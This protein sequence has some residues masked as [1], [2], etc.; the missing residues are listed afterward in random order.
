MINA[1]TPEFVEAHSLDI[2]LLSNLVNGTVRA[3]SFGGLFSWPLGYVVIRVQ[4]ERVQGYNEDQ[5]A[6]VIPD[7]TYFGSQ[8]PV[9]LGILTINWIINVIEESETDELSVLLSRSRISHLLACHQA[10]LSIGSKATANQTIDPTDLNEV[11]KMIK[12]WRSWPFFIKDH[13][14]LNKDYVFWQQYAHDDTDPEGWRWTPLASW[15]EHHKYLYQDDHREPVSCG[16]GEES[17]HCS[18]HHH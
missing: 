3:N 6:L 14:C 18:S 1:V 7:P 11:V 12:E 4:V 16:H 8:L 17:D 15:P 2:G 10:E 9:T 13:S 5:V